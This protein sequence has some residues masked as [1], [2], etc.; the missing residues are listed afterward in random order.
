MPDMEIL[1]ED[2]HLLVVNKPAGLP[3]MGAES[4]PTVHSLA[5]Q[6][7]KDNYGKPGRVFVGIVSRLDSMTSGV[8]VLARTSKAASRLTSQFASKALQTANH[9]NPKGKKAAAVAPRKIYL[10]VVEGA[11]DAEADRWKDQIRK[12]EAAHRMRLTPTN[13]PD[14]QTAELRYQMLARNQAN[15]TI[16]VELLTGRKHQIRTQFADREHPVLGDRK[17]GSQ[18]KF[19]AGIALHSWRL[20]I[21]HPTKRIPMWFEAPLPPSWKKFQSELPPRAMLSQKIDNYFPPPEPETW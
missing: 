18:Y 19:K 2:N 13:R 14:S 10:A 1:F 4:G 11:L 12:D 8:L 5:A 6:Y 3:T 15:T 7:I 9:P 16:A 17:Y 20:Q 21:E